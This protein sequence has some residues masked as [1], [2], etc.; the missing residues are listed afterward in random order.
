MS[1]VTAFVEPFFVPRREPASRGRGDGTLAAARRDS[2]IGLRRF[3]PACH[4]LA[5]GRQLAWGGRAL[6]IR[7]TLCG[8]LGK[9]WL[10]GGYLGRPALVEA[11]G[12][13]GASKRCCSK[14]SQNKAEAL[15]PF[16]LAKG[17]ASSPTQ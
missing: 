3:A 14:K 15:G 17:P 11:V 12:G 6:A 9:R 13:G 5:G 4:P 16:G 10:E 7:A 8:P 2:G 1:H